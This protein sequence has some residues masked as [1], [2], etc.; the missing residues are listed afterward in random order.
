MRAD[1]VSRMI[2]A[3]TPPRSRIGVVAAVGATTVDVRLGGEAITAGLQYNPAYV[4]GVG[5]R[6]L[7]V[8]TDSDWVVVC[9]VSPGASMIEDAERRVKPVRL[10][11]KA[12]AVSLEDIPPGTW[13]SQWEGANSGYAPQ[14]AQGRFP[15]PSGGPGWIPRYSDWASVAYHGSLAAQVPSGSTITGVSLVV[16]RSTGGQQ[17]APLVNPI[18]YG[19]AHD[20]ANPP[21]LNAAPSWVAGYGPL[22]Y[23]AVAMYEETRIVLPSTWVAA[24]LAGTIKG[25]GFWSD[26]QEQ[27]APYWDGGIDGDLVVRYTPPPTT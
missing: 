19:H 21:V 2:A 9:R 3:Q 7:V 10:W 17:G 1:T 4:P 13:Y 16:R 15:I 8:P 23:P 26:R 25:I 20:V 18:L 24:L 5:H 22:V 11:S 27:G 12:R 14:Y 6:V